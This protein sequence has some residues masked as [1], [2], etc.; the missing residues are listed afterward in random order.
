MKTLRFTS[1]PERRRRPLRLAVVGASPCGD[2]AAACCKR[3]VSEYAVLLQTDEERRRFAAWSLTLAVRDDEA[4][5]GIRHERVIAYREHADGIARCPFLG[6][7]DDDDRCTIYD[8]RPLSCRQFE[9]TRHFNEHGL[10]WHGTFLRGNTGVIRL[11]TT[12]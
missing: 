10:G 6:G 4:A 8:D 2:C 1:P 11:L 12:Y 9:C 5:G 7:D 3:T